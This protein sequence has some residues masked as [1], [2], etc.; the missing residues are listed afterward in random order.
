MYTPASK[1]VDDYWPELMPT[2]N[3]RLKFELN[4]FGPLFVSMDAHGNSLYQQN[5]HV[6]QDNLPAIYGKLGIKD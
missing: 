3:Q 4:E 5:A 1:I 2:D 6:A